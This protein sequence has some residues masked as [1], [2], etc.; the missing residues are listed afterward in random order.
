MALTSIINRN[1]GTG[2]AEVLARETLVE[3]RMVDVLVD[4][5]TGEVVHLTVGRHTL[6]K[7]TRYASAMDSIDMLPDGV[8]RRI[9]TATSDDFE[10]V[11]DER[12]TFS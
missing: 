5:V 11:M 8:T 2:D 9:I 3:P 7:E 12:E 1:Y 4:A 6:S 10:R